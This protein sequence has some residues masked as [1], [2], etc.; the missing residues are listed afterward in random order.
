[1][2]RSSFMTNPTPRKPKYLTDVKRGT[3]GL[4]LF[5]TE[6]IPRRRFVIE[7]WGKL[8]PD[9]KAQYIGGKYLFELGNGKTI[10]GTTRKNAARYIN[11]SCKPNCEVEIKGGRV[12]VFS[13]RKIKAGEELNY[14]YGKEYWD[15][16]IKPH[17]CRCRGC[18]TKK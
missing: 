12:F 7:Y 15:Y 8:I 3:S 9:E 5:A 14:D 4:G 17:G 2:M 13:K 16:Y 18:V 11:H 6:A 10:V 1:M